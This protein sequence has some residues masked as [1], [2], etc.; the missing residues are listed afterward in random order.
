MS[1]LSL[2][3]ISKHYGAKRALTNFNKEFTY[4]V[5]GLLGPNGA[6]KT[7]L[8][9]IIAGIISMDKGGAIKYNNCDV[10]SKDS[11]FK[12]HIGYM[13]QQQKLYDTFTPIRFLS[14]MAALKG[15]SKKQAQIQ[16]PE[17]LDNVELSDVANKKIKEFSGGMKQRLLIAQALL[18]NTDVI[19][20]DEPTAGLDPRQRVII[21]EK[22]A[23]CSKNKIVIISTHIVSD[24][25]T[26][27]DEI[28]LLKEGNI[29]LEGPIDKLKEDNQTDRLE[30]LYMKYFDE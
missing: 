20:L 23:K 19:L 16:I 18:G 29:I 26:I 3:N 11:D 13:P 28:I 1:K 7:T 2:T 8:I 30:T 6:G 12:S 15:I 14:Y 4:G 9:N 24:I 21:R 25:E 27:A 5:Y 22:I 10:F 17:L